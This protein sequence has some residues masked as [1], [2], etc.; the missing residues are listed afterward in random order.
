MN[1]TNFE[2]AIL[3]RLA[4]ANGEPVSKEELTKT[5]YPNGPSPNPNSNGLEVFVGRIRQKIGRE[6]IV[7]RR[8]VGYV[9]LPEQPL[10][11]QQ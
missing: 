6:R 9:L 10:Q 7:T 4:D 11:E 1:L 3:K 8:G 5:L 2:N